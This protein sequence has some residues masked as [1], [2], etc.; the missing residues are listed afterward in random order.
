ME[1]ALPRQRRPDRVAERDWCGEGFR[2]NESIH[3]CELRIPTSTCGRRPQSTSLQS[4]RDFLGRK[5][6]PLHFPHHSAPSAPSEWATALLTNPNDHRHPHWILR[7]PS[8]G[9]KSASSPGL[10]KVVRPLP[11]TNLW[12]PFSCAPAAAM[13]TVEHWAGVLEFPEK[14]LHGLAQQHDGVQPRQEPDSCS[15]AP[16]PPLLA[17]DS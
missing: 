8:C 4:A 14:E 15:K 1:T 5:R 3:P 9:R 11:H 17:G 6:T 10:L 13:T 16:Q 12:P 2:V 7:G